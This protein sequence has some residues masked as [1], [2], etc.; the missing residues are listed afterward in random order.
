MTQPNCQIV[1]LDTSAS[2]ELFRVILTKMDLLRGRVPSVT[3]A[4]SPQWILSHARRVPGPIR[5]ELQL[6]TTVW[7][8]HQDT[9]VQE[10]EIQSLIQTAQPEPSATM[11]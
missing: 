9:C 5:S 6:L 8:V 3:T 10:L 2:L 7:P 11:A 1:Q 4:V